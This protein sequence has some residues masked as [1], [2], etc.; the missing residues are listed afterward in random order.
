MG[1]IF[2]GGCPRSRTQNRF[3]EMEDVKARIQELAARLAKL[4]FLGVVPH[5]Q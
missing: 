1:L 3:G 2:A 4:P 5:A